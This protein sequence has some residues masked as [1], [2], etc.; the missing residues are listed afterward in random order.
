VS[1]R[2]KDIRDSSFLVGLYRFTMQAGIVE[3]EKQARA[4]TAQIFTAA[5]AAVTFDPCTSL[6]KTSVHLP[7]PRTGMV[8]VSVIVCTHNPEPDRLRRTLDSLKDQSLARDQW[9][10]LIVDNASDTKVSG[11]FDVSWHARG[12]H[13][14]E[15]KLGLTPA[16]LRGIAEAEGELLVFV[17]DD[18]VLAPMFLKEASDIWDGHPYLGAFGAGRL[19]PEFEIPPVPEL[20][21]RLSLLALRNVTQ[22]QWSNNIKDVESIPWGAG[23]CVSRVVADAYRRFVDSLGSDVIGVLGRRGRELFA[24]EDDVFSWVAASLGLGFGIFPSLRLTHLIPASRLTRRY[25]LK[26]IH[27]HAFS[28]SVRQYLMAGTAPRR[29]DGIRYVHIL[30]HGIRNGGFSMQ[31]QWAE[32]RGVNAAAQFTADNRLRPIVLGSV[33]DAHPMRGRLNAM[34]QPMSS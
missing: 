9:E 22:V 3:V 31:C 27:D 34:A 13:V 6:S 25:F 21:P 8:R 1:W 2:R 33:V 17:D 4:L 16:R 26:L 7:V 15:E 32:S 5:S 19:E 24:G 23:L 11:A 28:N 29:I 14:R 20:R 10:L 30:L 18:N 12:R